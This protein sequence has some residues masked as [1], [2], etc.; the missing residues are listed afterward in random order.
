MES[1]KRFKQKVKAVHSGSFAQVAMDLFH[2]QRKNNAAY[3]DYLALLNIDGAKVR[4]LAQIPCL[5]IEC[6][7]THPI[8]TGDWQAEALFMSSGTTSSSRS[9]HEVEDVDYYL[10]HAR[11]TF[12]QHYGAIKDM[13]VFALLPH[14]Q[15]QGHSSLVKMVDDFIQ[16]AHDTY[17]GFYLDHH[18]GLADD[19]R[20]ALAHEPSQKVLLFG[21]GYALLDFAEWVKHQ[22]VALDGLAI[23]ETGGMKGRRKE[24][25]KEEF[26][27]LLKQGLG[28]VTIHSEYGM[29]EMLSQ[30]YS[31]DE[32]FYLPAPSMHVLIR[33]LYDPFHLLA[34][35][36][37]GG[38]N[39]I[40]LANV[41]SCAFI[42]TQDIGRKPDEE[43]FEV[44]GRIDHAEQRGCNLLVI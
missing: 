27:H 37:A 8:K 38:I 20:K 26:Y 29:T 42:E 25:I 7:K 36:K 10:S 34:N 21:V 14:Y 18:E 24:M 11:A 43:R 22:G 32:R 40:D 1:L 28:A 9:K 12:E 17:G 44:L 39:I 6:F 33:D 5:P 30:A 19:L 35:G 2:Y 31:T 41:H 3:R 4:S 13:F 23:I 15:A 16:S